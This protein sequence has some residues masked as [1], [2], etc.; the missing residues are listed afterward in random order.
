MP[1]GRGLCFLSEFFSPLPGAV[2]GRLDLCHI[3]RL[4]TLGPRGHLELDL[5]SFLQALE[6]VALNGGV[7]DKYVFPGLLLDKAKTLCVVKP[8][9]FPSCHL[10][11]L[12]LRS[13]PA[14]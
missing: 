12:V 13:F 11:L 14:E 2:S 10:F 9:H 6:P 1:A 8:L 7:M 4:G 5:L 3:G